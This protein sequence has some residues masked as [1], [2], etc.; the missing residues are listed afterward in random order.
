VKKAPTYYGDISFTAESH[1]AAGLLLATVDMPKR[2]SLKKLFV[3][4][5]H[6]E[7][8]PIQSVTVNGQNWTGFDTGN[9]WVV[10]EKPLPEHYTI[11]AHY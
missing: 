10:I 6:P 11:V 1:A 8:K 9:E 5:R 7:A 2:Q 4:F 3:R